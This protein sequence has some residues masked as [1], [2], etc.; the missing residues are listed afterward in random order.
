MMQWSEVNENTKEWLDF[1][2]SFSPTIIHANR[3]LKGWI[4]EG[5]GISK[6]HISAQ[7]LREAAAAFID[8]ADW[9]EKRSHYPEV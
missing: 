7:E 4:I 9:L 8:A 2:G 1:F 6:A 5:E 3:E